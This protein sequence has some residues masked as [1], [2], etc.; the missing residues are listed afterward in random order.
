M[1]MGA[2]VLA[3]WAPRKPGMITGVFL[4]VYGVLRILTETIREADE[5][6]GLVFGLQRGQ[7]LSVFLIVVGIV[8]CSWTSKRQTRQ[9]GGLSK[10]PPLDE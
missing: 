10:R 3:W 1:L 9:V 6:V 8:V 5:G 4:V 2:L 7:L